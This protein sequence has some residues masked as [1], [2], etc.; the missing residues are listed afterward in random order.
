MNLPWALTGVFSSPSV[1]DYSGLSSSLALVFSWFPWSPMTDVHSLFRDLRGFLHTLWPSP[2]WLPCRTSSLISSPFL[3]RD[4]NLP[5]QSWLATGWL[6][7]ATLFPYLSKGWKLPRGRMG[8]YKRGLIA[9]SCC[10]S[11]PLQFLLPLIVS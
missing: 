2:R 10:E 9:F 6:S 5:P 3:A 11:R 1:A 4:L 7:S 8:Q